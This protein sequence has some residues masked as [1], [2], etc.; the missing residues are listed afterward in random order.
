MIDKI[1]FNV[2][3]Q[4]FNEGYDDYDSLPKEDSMTQE[5]A[6]RR[7]ITFPHQTDLY[8]A[9]MAKF[10]ICEFSIPK[11]GLMI[12][13]TNSQNLNFRK[14]VEKFREVLKLQLEDTW[15]EEL[16]N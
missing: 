7:Y 3:C 1:T 11:Y 16:Y 14:D 10:W 6:I 4:L 9:L 12:A 15:D 2:L 8:D 13:L 5:D